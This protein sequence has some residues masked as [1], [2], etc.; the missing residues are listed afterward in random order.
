MLEILNCIKMKKLFILLI[1]ITSLF[2]C[3]HRKQQIERL[4]VVRDSLNQVAYAKD[5]AIMEFLTGFNE[6]QANLDSIKTVEKLVTVSSAQPGEMNSTQKKQIL[7]DISLINQLLQKNKEMTADLQK[8]LKNANSKVGQLQGMIAEFE[9]MVASL[10][11]QIEMKDVE[12]AQLSQEVQRLNIDVSQL[13]NQVQKVTQESQDKSQ[14]INTQTIALNK[15]YYAIGTVREL[16]ENNV[17]VK[18]GGVLG[19]GRTLKM[20]KDFNRDYFTEIDIRKFNVLPLMVKKVKVVS[21][22]PVGSYHISGEKRADTLFIDNSQ[23][24]W[25]V[26]KYLLIALD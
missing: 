23:E 25:K 6:I 21:V 3:Q 20:K 22:H 18:S 9:K 24:F 15:A 26:S 13:T 4:S 12:I 7:E 17:L 14:V 5:S 10:N 11:S 16:K 1:L 2:G 8:K 19:M